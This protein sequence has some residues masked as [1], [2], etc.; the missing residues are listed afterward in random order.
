VVRNSRRWCWCWWYGNRGVPAENDAEGSAKVEEG[1]ITTTD[2]KP[3]ANNEEDKDG[4]GVSNQLKTLTKQFE[5]A[6]EGCSQQVPVQ[7][8]AAFAFLEMRIGMCKRDVVF[9]KDDEKA[10]TRVRWERGEFRLLQKIIFGVHVLFAELSLPKAGYRSQIRSLFSPFYSHHITTVV[11]DASFH[12]DSL[13]AARPNSVPGAVPNA[14]D[15][16]Y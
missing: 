5:Q 7:I 3:N 9:D 4:R 2:A 1:A 15:N 10:S 6:I 14:N 11:T 16:H 12:S 13:L 8:A